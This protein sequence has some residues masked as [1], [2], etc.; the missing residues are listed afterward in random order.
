MLLATRCALV[1]PRVTAVAVE[2]AEFAVSA[3]RL[4]VAAVPAVA[5]NGSVRW[6]GNVPERLFVERLLAAAA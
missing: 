2:A 6:T 3:D 1:S 4:G 5:V